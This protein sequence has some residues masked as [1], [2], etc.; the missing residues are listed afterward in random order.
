MNSLFRSQNRSRRVFRLCQMLFAAMFIVFTISVSAQQPQLTLADIIIGLRSKKVTI[1]ERN[2]ILAGAV[3]ERGITFAMTPEIEKE[4]TA[5][6][7][8]KVLI[9][10]VK[11]KAVA[12]A[13]TPA[14]TPVPTPTPDFIFYKTRADVNLGKGE[15]ALALPDYD[16]AVTLKP[17]SSIAFLNRGR[18]YYSLKDYP[19]AS[20]DFD[21]SI[22]LDPK[23]SKAYYNRGLLHESQGELEKALA[24]Y[25]K[26]VDLDAANEPAK[27]MVKKMSDQLQAKAAEKTPAPEP[28]K[29]VPTP[30]K[31][32]E[33]MNLGN[34]S[35]ANAVKMVKPV[36]PPV[37]QKS[38]IEGKVVVEVA[39]DIE[40]NVVSAK[41]T[42]GHQFLRAAAEDAAKRSKFRPA[43]FNGQAIKATGTITY[44]FT[45]RPGSEE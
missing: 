4:L 3:K 27:A 35:A 10:A 25:Q 24:D 42:S 8:S 9:D 29:T 32:P 6:G 44:N 22:E 33:S 36:F 19:K 7:A 20:A 23:D 34:L 40:G 2:T 37:A 26:A 16:K 1:E 5:T 21:K 14:P 11:E 41:A 38:N 17:D 45:L 31:A 12:V 30:V 43:M 13:P 39:L 28:L 18:T 15:Y